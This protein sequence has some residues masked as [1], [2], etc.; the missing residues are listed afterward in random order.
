MKFHEFIKMTRKERGKTLIQLA[1]ESG[2]S[3]SMLYRIEDGALDKPHPDHLK[4]L[5][6]PLNISY[7]SMMQIAGYLPKKSDKKTQALPLLKKI[8]VISW[9]TLPKVLSGTKDIPS[10][11][12]NTTIDV[13]NGN[14]QMVAIK[15]QNN[16]YPPFKQ[17]QVMVLKKQHPLKQG[18]YAFIVMGGKNELGEVL[19]VNGKTV[20]K[21]LNID[22]LNN[23]VPITDKNKWAKVTEIRL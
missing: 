15:L 13:A 2:L 17:G 14:G 16:Q 9:Q 4:V 12:S 10:E 19:L 6:K 18:D 5:S 7:E 23:I 22:Q 3:Y 1:E 21:S 20:I 8:P 11:I